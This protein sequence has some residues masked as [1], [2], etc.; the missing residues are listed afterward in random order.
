[1]AVLRWV[2]SGEKLRS[3]TAGVSGIHEHETIEEAQCGPVQRRVAVIFLQC[4]FPG[5]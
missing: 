1:M 5:M 4:L 2:E 3:A